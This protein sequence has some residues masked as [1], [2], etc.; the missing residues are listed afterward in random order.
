MVDG[1]IRRTDRVLVNAANT[2]V[3]PSF[4]LVDVVAQ[5]NLTRRLALRVNLNTRPTKSTSA[6]SNNNGGRYNPGNP[7]SGLFTIVANY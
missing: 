3:V 7:R 5:C 2:I 6:T 1:G 4:Q